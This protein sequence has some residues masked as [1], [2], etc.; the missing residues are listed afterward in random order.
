MKTEQMVF[1]KNLSVFSTLIAKKLE[2][3]QTNEVKLDCNDKS[4]QP[5]LVNAIAKS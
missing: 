3:E 5:M 2:D 1:R 4:H